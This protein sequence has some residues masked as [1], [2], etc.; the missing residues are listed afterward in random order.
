MRIGYAAPEFPGQTHT[1]FWREILGLEALGAEVVPISTR[2]PPRHVMPHDW[3]AAAAARTIYLASTAPGAAART[4]L[5]WP[6]ALWGLRGDMAR[7]GAGDAAR[8]AAMA[9]F[10]AA[11]V[12]HAR[13]LALDHVHVGSCG[14]T[15]LIAAMARRLGG[16]PYS[17]TLHNPVTIFGPLQ[18]YKWG[19][20]AFGSVITR[21]LRDDLETR[22][23]PHLP[24][25][26]FVQSMGVD[27]DRFR[28]P[29]PY[30]PWDGEGPFRIFCCGR[31]NR[32]KGH[33]ELIAAVADLRAAGLPAELRIAGEDDAGGQGYRRQLEV[34]L[35]ERDMG[36]AVTLLGAVGEDRIL[37]EL[38]A[39]HAFALASHAEPLGVAYMEAMSC[40]LPVVGTRAG[41]VPE[42][43]EDGATGLLVPPK[44]PAALAAALR[45]L[46]ETPD[47]ARAMGRTAR[48]VVEE[49]F[50]AAIGAERIFERI[51]RR[52]G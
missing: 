4:G 48:T 37:A 27:T 41:G 5:G 31:L 35:A 2:P 14:Q 30:A 29:A 24:D 38:L 50:R 21:A 1:F 8:M 51:A 6:G 47:L 43:I 52:T 46:A 20:A 44:D 10:A 28:R 7:Q 42:M 49:R 40:E 34:A 25:D 15:A 33:E 39:A 16:P 12:R 18:P 32:V 3:S 9:P 13:A 17:L 36:G 26:V 22:Y 45:R 23:G 11:L 19:H